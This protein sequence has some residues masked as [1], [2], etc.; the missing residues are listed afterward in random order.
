M[1]LPTPS[2][3]MCVGPN[4]YTNLITGQT[5]MLYPHDVQQAYLQEQAQMQQHRQFAMSNGYF[6]APQAQAQPQGAFNFAPQGF[7]NPWQG[8]AGPQ[9]HYGGY[10]APYVP[11]QQAMATPAVVPV[12][13]R[14]AIPAPAPAPAPSS[15]LA[16]AQVHSPPR[17]P[18]S[19]P[20]QAPASSPLPAPTSEDVV[21]LTQETS[22]E[23]PVVAPATKVKASSS[24]WKKGEANLKLRLNTQGGSNLLRLFDSMSNLGPSQG[25]Y[26]Y[27]EAHWPTEEAAYEDITE[28]STYFIDAQEM[29]M[30]ALKWDGFAGFCSLENPSDEDLVERERQA[31]EIAAEK[32]CLRMDLP[33]KVKQKKAREEH[34]QWINWVDNLPRRKFKEVFKLPRTPNNIAEVKRERAEEIEREIAERVAL[35]ARERARNAESLVKRSSKKRKAKSL[36]EEPSKKSKSADLS[37]SGSDIDA[38]GETD[39]ES[40]TLPEASSLPEESM[41]MPMCALNSPPSLPASPLLR[42][43]SPREENTVVIT[44]EQVADSSVTSDEAPS[45]SEVDDTASL[46]EDDDTASLFEDDDMASLFGDNDEEEEQVMLIELDSFDDLPPELASYLSEENTV[47]NTEEQV[48]APKYSLGAG[49]SSPSTGAGHSSPHRATN[50]SEQVTVQT[51]LALST[52]PREENTVVIAQEQVTALPSPEQVIYPSMFEEIDAFLAQ[53]ARDSILADF[54]APHLQGDN[55]ISVNRIS[56]TL[57]NSAFGL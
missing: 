41:D 48:T 53:P 52:S 20:P 1:S 42:P 54:Y 9:A 35:L 23:E 22:A 3:L 17:T 44:E 4:Y 34:G 27:C 46:F 13:A 29:L 26:R 8:T 33:E 49:H 12:P 30:Y 56:D 19:P 21:D 57:L 39:D 25:K 11:V 2:Y 47:V 15:A 32:R 55:T 7:G 38:E 51:G 31:A 43:T 14:A 45:M 10:N 5:A 18:V 36:V 50:P 37:S 28:M 40:Q 24:F 6:F 16:P